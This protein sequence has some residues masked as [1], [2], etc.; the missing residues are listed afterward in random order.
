LILY[1][2]KILYIIGQKCQRKYNK[3]RHLK[4]LYTHLK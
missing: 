4:N 3:R 2:D 1:I